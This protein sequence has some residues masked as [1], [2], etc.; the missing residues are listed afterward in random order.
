M[1][2]LLAIILETSRA[3]LELN[4]TILDNTPG[5]GT[6]NITVNGTLYFD[7]DYVNITSKV[8]VALDLG[9]F[10]IPEGCYPCL[11]E[12]YCAN[13]YFPFMCAGSTGCTYNEKMKGCEDMFENVTERIQHCEE[14]QALEQDYCIVEDKCAATVKGACLNLIDQITVSE[15]LGLLGYSMD[16]ASA[17]DIVS[18][19]FYTSDNTTIPVFS[20]YTSVLIVAGILV[21][22][23]FACIIYLYRERKEQ[24]IF[25]L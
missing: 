6:C 23:I 14:C 15:N 1:V 19:P 13:I 24:Q 16:C 4:T 21:L 9:A 18:F 20:G 17:E 5:L 11:G 22:M 7:V 2:V 3:F 12:N 10:T 8:R 25:T